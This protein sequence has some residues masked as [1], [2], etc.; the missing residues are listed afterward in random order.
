V[1][2]NEVKDN[3][4]RGMNSCDVDYGPVLTAAIET[5]SRQA[6]MNTLVVDVINPL[7]NLK[8]R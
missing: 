2:W 1:A 6:F 3:L 8:V 4:D 7:T 5:R